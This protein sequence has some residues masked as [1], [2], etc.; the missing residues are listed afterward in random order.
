VISWTESNSRSLDGMVLVVVTMASVIA[1]DFETKLELV[2][3]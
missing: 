2:V 3:M 1:R